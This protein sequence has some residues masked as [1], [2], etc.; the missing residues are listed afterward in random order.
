M[1]GYLNN[2][3]INHV[4]FHLNH[5]FELSDD[6]RSRMIFL[7]ASEK[8]RLKN[9]KR[10]IVFLLS[11]QPLIIDKIKN[12]GE[13]PILFPISGTRNSYVNDSNE[14]LIFTDDLLKSSF[15]L[16]SGY[17]EYQSQ[18]KDHLGRFPY[19]KSIQQR[20]NIIHKPVVNYYFEYIKNPIREFCKRRSI[21]FRT[22]NI[23]SP[24]AFH[25]THDVDKIDFYTKHY[26]AYKIKQTLG[27]TK[28]SKSF[29]SNIKL[30]L[31]GTIQYLDFINRKNPA[32]DF[33]Y[34]LEL[35]KKHQFTSTFFFLDKD[36]HHSDAYYRLD[37]KR[38]HRLMQ[39][40]HDE[41]KEIGLHGTV[42]SGFD[43]KKMKEIFQRITKVSPSKVEGIRQHRLLMDFPDTFA[44]QERVGLKYDS[45]LGF[46]A[47]EG[48]RN[49]YCL[50]FKPYDFKRNKIFDIWEIPLQVMDVTLFEYRKLNVSQAIENIRVLIDEITKFNGVFTLLWHNGYFDEAGRRGLRNFYEQLLSQVASRNPEKLSGREIIWKIS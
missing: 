30:L 41:G 43:P 5:T 24:F 17:Q 6:I 3:Q 9:I 38:I 32:W 29:L 22:K 40:L 27:I 1:K 35:E 26:V 14:N 45:T 49:S 21:A 42:R 37:E 16:L 7:P 15:Y 25:L 18:F 2:A 44:I 23:Y 33:D 34:L 28:S 4:L 13:V 19:K 46:A 48:F 50:P 36:I 20:L 31:N 12:K 11:D 39:L 47:H 10:K 8:S